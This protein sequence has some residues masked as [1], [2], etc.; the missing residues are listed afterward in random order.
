MDVLLVVAE[1]LVLFE[2]EVC[3]LERYLDTVGGLW[4]L[5]Y[6]FQVS[7]VYL[8]NKVERVLQAGLFSAGVS[9][10]R[11]GGREGVLFGDRVKAGGIFLVLVAED[12]VVPLVDGA[13]L[14]F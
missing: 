6:V 5:F 2:C 11:R 8:V 1:Q 3:G 10:R 9:R 7:P 14:V 13:A 4:R 12:M